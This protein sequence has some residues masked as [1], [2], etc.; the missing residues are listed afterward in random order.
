MANPEL[1]RIVAK[2]FSQY[3]VPIDLGLEWAEEIHKAKSIDDLSLELKK[4]I[5]SPRDLK[6]R[7]KS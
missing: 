7:P 2:L 3:R 4:F 5:E 6:P 1:S